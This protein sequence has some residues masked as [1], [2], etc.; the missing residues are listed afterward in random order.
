MNSAAAASLP[1]RR[2]AGAG[3]LGP[4]SAD[5]ER[6]AGR[7]FRTDQG[8]RM[9]Q[10]RTVDRHARSF[11][12]PSFTALC[13]FLDSWLPGEAP[14]K[15]YYNCTLMR[16]CAGL[17]CP[18]CGCRLTSRSAVRKDGVVCTDCG[19]PLDSSTEV[20]HAWFPWRQ[21]L[22]VLSLL[23]TCLALIWAGDLLEARRQVKP[24]NLELQP[25]ITPL[26][27]GQDEKRSP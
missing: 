13:R 1:L 10:P 24:I 18:R 17:A 16:R 9:D 20:L 11:A 21:S 25:K 27:A 19:L 4:G 2:Q 6:A 7:S 15:R 12:D 23:F 8:E 26:D 3:D 5:L 14:I 22:V